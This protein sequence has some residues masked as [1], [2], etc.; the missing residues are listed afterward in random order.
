MMITTATIMQV[1]NRIQTKIQI[2]YW[3]WTGT[4]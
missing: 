2:K 4:R 1:P 3:T